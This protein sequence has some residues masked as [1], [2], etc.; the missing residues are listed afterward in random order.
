MSVMPSCAA[1]ILSPSVQ[2]IRDLSF[3]V[4]QHGSLDLFDQ[5]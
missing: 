5:L 1:R 2:V 4:L 3:D